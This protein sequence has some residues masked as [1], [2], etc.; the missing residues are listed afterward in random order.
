M[1][2]LFEQFCADLDWFAL[3]CA[4]LHWFALICAELRWFALICADLCW[5]ALI[6]A[7][8]IR[9]FPGLTLF[10][11]FK[12]QSKLMSGKKLET[13]NHFH[14]RIPVHIQYSLSKVLRKFLINVLQV[15]KFARHKHISWMTK[16]PR[17]YC[18]V[19]EFDF[20]I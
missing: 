19:L 2:T 9:F 15:L 6:C 17:I 20:V 8:L 13:K 4:D 1:P 5:F 7:D 11:T 12:T 14:C 10:E 3:I 18:C 16:F